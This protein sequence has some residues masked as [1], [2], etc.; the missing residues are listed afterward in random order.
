MD[1]GFGNKNQQVGSVAASA[2]AQSTRAQEQTIE[3]ELDYYDRLLEDEDALVE[4]RKKRME[5]LKAQHAQK[6]RWKELGHGTYSELGGGQNADAAK[7][8]FE[9]SKKSERLVVHFYR[10]TTR[11]C[12]IFHA[13]LSKLAP[14]HVGTRF[15]KI[16]VENCENQGGGASFLVERLHVVVMPTLVL[17]KDRNAFHQLEGFDEMGGSDKFPASEL[18]RVL[19]AH[20]MLADEDDN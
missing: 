11:F 20:G 12:D 14:R 2:L 4:L 7:E 10:P 19:A 6:L 13:H 17:V 18:E 16:N 5:S 8:F 3:D 9:A 15:V 1:L